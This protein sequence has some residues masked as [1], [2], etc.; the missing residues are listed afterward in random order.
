[1]VPS[2]RVAVSH[3]IS[4]QLPT[5]LRHNLRR[6]MVGLWA[7]VEFWKHDALDRKGLTIRDLPGTVKL[8][9]RHYKYL[10]Y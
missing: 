3:L 10:D 4:E 2:V 5:P 8:T 9:P 7:S 6:P 1:M